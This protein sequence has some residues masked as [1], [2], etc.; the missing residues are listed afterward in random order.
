MTKRK[1]L[2]ASGA[3]N[4]KFLQTSPV[5]MFLK[6]LHKIKYTPTSV[7]TTKTSSSFSNKYLQVCFYN[8]SDSSSLLVSTCIILQAKPGSHLFSHL[9]VNMA[10][11]T[12]LALQ[13]VRKCA[14]MAVV[15]PLY[16]CTACYCLS[17]PSIPGTA[18]SS[19]LEAMLSTGSL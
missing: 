5:Q 4:E 6:R 10:D 3:E 13:K 19:L 7:S 14:R 11:D 12:L 17:P 15:L 2:D 8:R 18:A 1:N 9:A 16:G